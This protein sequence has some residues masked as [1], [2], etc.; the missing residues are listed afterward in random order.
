M[1]LIWSECDVFGSLDCDATWLLLVWCF[2]FDEQNLK[3][4][5]GLSRDRHFVLFFHMLAEWLVATGNK[6]VGS[7]VP[8]Y[9]CNIP[10]QPSFGA[11]LDFCRIMRFVHSRLIPEIFSSCYGSNSVPRPWSLMPVPN[12]VSRDGSMACWQGSCSTRRFS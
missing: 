1:W 4:I 7:T 9:A 11:C 5:A 6:R 8:E 10:Q 12:V 2:L 3:S